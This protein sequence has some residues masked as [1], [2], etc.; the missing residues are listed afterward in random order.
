MA[1]SEQRIEVRRSRVPRL[2]LRLV[3]FVLA[4]GAGL[5]A[6]AGAL[7][8]FHEQEAGRILPGITIAGVDVGGRTPDEARQIVADRFVSL[9]TGGIVLRSGLGSMTIAFADVGRG[10]DV[11]AMVADAAGQGRGGTWLDE[12]IAAIRLRLHGID[13]PLRLTYDDDLAAAAVARFAERTAL[14]SIDASVTRSAKSFGIVRGTD[15]RSIDA[16][17]TLAAVDAAMRDTATP[18][19]TGVP[20][21]QRRV[22]PTLTTEM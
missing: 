11:D 15:A 7:A 12:S 8:A 3:L 6:A 1:V 14:R 5:G 17:A 4:G 22:P 18:A 16:T 21:G 2:L 20:V 19:G 10:A 9:R 13:V